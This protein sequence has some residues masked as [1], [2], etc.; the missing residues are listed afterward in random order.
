MA[1]PHEVIEAVRRAIEDASLLSEI[2][3]VRTQLLDA[4]GFDSATPYPLCELTIVSQVRS[5]RANTDYVRDVTNDDGEVI[6]EILDAIWTM[7]LQADIFVP[8]VPGYSATELGGKL[9][10]ALYR[11]D[12]EVRGDLLYDATGDPYQSI[13][14]LLVQDGQRQDDLSSS[15][16]LRRWRQSL[17]VDFSDRINTV[18]LYGP[19][20]PIRSVSTPVPGAMVGGGPGEPEIQYDPSLLAEGGELGT[21][22]HGTDTLGGERDYQ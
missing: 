10:K 3:A 16:S 7:D 13:A 12:D 20:Q 17:R 11:Y 18:D 22:Q 5:T 6:G 8:A 14:G 19:A 9:Q 15:P 21:T 4:S 1:T 2:E